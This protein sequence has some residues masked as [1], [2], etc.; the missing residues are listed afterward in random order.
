MQPQIIAAATRLVHKDRKDAMKDGQKYGLSPGKVF[1]DIY[2]EHLKANDRDCLSN[3]S[4]G[5]VLWQAQNVLTILTRQSDFTALSKN[6]RG[7]LPSLLELY[8]RLIDQSCTGE[9]I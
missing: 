8:P 4:L 3:S 2:F 9:S 5:C 7:E 6:D 1:D